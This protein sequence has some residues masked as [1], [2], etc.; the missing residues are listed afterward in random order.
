MKNTDIKTITI[1]DSG[2]SFDVVSPVTDP[3]SSCGTITGSI[4]SDVPGFVTSTANPLIFQLVPSALSLNQGLKSVN[5][6]LQLQ[7]A[8]LPAP[9]EF[10]FV[11][12]YIDCT[13]T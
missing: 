9:Q 6:K 2:W 1:T 12:E 7:N 4:V 8:N 13:Q 11:I 10:P 3:I 5:M